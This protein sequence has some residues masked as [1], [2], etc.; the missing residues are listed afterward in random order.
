MIV[1]M[2]LHFASDASYRKQA[3][4]H[5]SLKRKETP[6]PPLCLKSI[7]QQMALFSHPCICFLYYCSTF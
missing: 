5:A 3:K 1:N 7:D 4:L 6:L 2:L